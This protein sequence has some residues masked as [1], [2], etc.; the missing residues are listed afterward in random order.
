MT[1]GYSCKS[2][3][4][5][6]LGLPLSYGAQ[7]PVYWDSIPAEERQQRGELSSDQ[8]VIDDEYFFVLGRLEIPVIGETE[9]FSWNVWV[10][11]SE[12]SFV[13]IRE[14]LMT[15]GRE[16]EPPYFGWLSTSLPCYPD[17]LNLKTHLHT[18]PIGERPFVELEG[19]GHPLAVEQR[20]GITMQRVQEIAECVLHG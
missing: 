15:H 20:N 4:E 12:T 13:R 16:R 17:T 11:L 14:L 19:T 6:H 7:A 10:S 18:R 8:C 9:P 2:C 3:G 1:D 5:F